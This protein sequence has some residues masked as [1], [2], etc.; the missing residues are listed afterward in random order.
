MAYK[1]TPPTE[2]KKRTLYKLTPPKTIEELP[3][4]YGSN[5]ESMVEQP[6]SQQDI[7]P[8]EFNPE[9]WLVNQRIESEQP[10]TP[11]GVEGLRVAGGAVA[12][13]LESLVSFPQE[14]YQGLRGMINPVYEKMTGKESPLPE[15]LPLSAIF[16]PVGFAKEQGR[17]ML[18]GQQASSSFEPLQKAREIGEGITSL[19][20]DPA[21]FISNLPSKLTGE[22]EKELMPS[23]PTGEESREFTQKLTGE[24]FEPKSWAEGLMQNFV[25]EVTPIV[26]TMPAFEAPTFWK[27]ANVAWSTA[28]SDLAEW[29][30]E[31]LKWSPAAQKATKVGSYMLLSLLGPSNTKK[32]KNNLVKDAMKEI[33]N[34]PPAGK[35]VI[36]KTNKAGKEIIKDVEELERR[37]FKVTKSTRPGKSEGLSV[38]GDLKDKLENMDKITIQELFDT[39]QALYDNL[40][41]GG[42]IPRDLKKYLTPLVKRIDDVILEH[43]RKRHPALIGPYTKWKEVSS[44]LY[45]AKEVGDVLRPDKFLLKGAKLSPMSLLLLTPKIGLQGVAQILG[46]AKLL[47]VIAR[48]FFSKQ[49]FNSYMN[50]LKSAGV[51]AIVPTLNAAK[52]FDRKMAAE[53]TNYKNLLKE[54]DLEKYIKT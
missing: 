45:K 6:F 36:N 41:K 39:Q 46:G 53:I 5:V 50:T 30:A 1:L 10:K 7:E 24:V 20:N 17:R 4:D 21:S 35:Y 52:D 26:A 28:G 16:N 14:G 37:K 12:R 44:A 54:Y 19:Y 23:T 34:P 22:K 49:I 43:A 48:P 2:N 13:G 15:K 29:G 11:L 3:E 40:Y 51:G 8:P 31:K 25:S 18:S 47:E 33:D 9:E 32:L 38:L 27:L 42:E